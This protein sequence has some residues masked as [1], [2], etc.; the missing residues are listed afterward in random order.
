M[1]IPLANAKIVGV[2]VTMEKTAKVLP[3]ATI[4][5]ENTEI[6]ITTAINNHHNASIV[7]VHTK[8]TIED[9]RKLFS[10]R[11]T[12]RIAKQPTPKE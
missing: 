2:W 8:Q 4:A 12:T 6:P 5:L 1:C 9:A 7:M 11:R 10:E 3:D